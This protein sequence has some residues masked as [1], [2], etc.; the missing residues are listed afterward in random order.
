MDCRTAKEWMATSV[1]HASDPSETVRVHLS[2]CPSCRAELEVWRQTWALLAAWKDAEPPTRVDRAV[3]AEVQGETEAARTSVGGLKSGP[4]WAAAAAAAFL[5]IIASLFLPY[6]DSLRFC[7]KLLSDTGVSIPALPLS[8]FVGLP[9]A[10]LPLVAVV[11]ASMFLKANGHK[12]QALAVGQAFAV[13]MVPYVA[14]ACGDLEGPV[15]G[16][17]LLGTVGGATLAGAASQWLIRQ[18]PAG[19][20]A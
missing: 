18:S 4:A 13:I 10:F 6:Q 9:Y 11:L 8:F 12:I 19:A 5:A 1:A 3:L 14:F 2:Q 15:I 20:P 16:G 7:G 17:I